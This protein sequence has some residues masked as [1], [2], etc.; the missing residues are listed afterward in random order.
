MRHVLFKRY[1]V[2]RERKTSDTQNQ[3]AGFT[4]VLIRMIDARL[5]G[6][7]GSPRLSTS[8][9]AFAQNAP[10]RRRSYGVVCPP[11]IFGVPRSV[12][13]PCFVFHSEGDALIKLSRWLGN[14][15]GASEGWKHP[16][17]CFLWKRS[18][19]IDRLLQRRQ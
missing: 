2:C 13:P 7:Y 9:F 6:R 8:L 17:A 11:M 18:A 19:E 16:K 14:S 3:Y 1:L 12:L 15:M 10:W 4:A 5:L